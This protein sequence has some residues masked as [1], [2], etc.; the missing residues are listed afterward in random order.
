MR[1]YI[2]DVS[3]S[4]A[5]QRLGVTRTALSR[6]LNGNAGVSADMALRLEQALGTSAKMWLEMSLKCCIGGQ[7]AARPLNASVGTPNRS[8]SPQIW[9]Q[10]R[11]RL[12]ARM[13]DTTG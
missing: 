9:R 11:E 7:P 2:G 10:F 3:V 4:E 12:P 8:D 1:E 6:I 13:A 5:A